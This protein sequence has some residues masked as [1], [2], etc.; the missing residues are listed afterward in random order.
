[1]TPESFNPF[2]PPLHRE[3]VGR[4]DELY[5][6]RRSKFARIGWP[7]VFAL[8]LVVPVMLVV[9]NQ[10][11]SGQLGAIAAFIMLLMMGWRLCCQYPDFGRKLVIGSIFVAL[12]QVF[13]I[14]HF[15]A[16]IVAS[17]VLSLFSHRA[18]LNKAGRTLATRS[19]GYRRQRLATACR[20][21][22]VA[23]V[24]DETKFAVR[25]GS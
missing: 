10:P 9:V 7:V 17:I 5:A 19:D 11:W 25:S 6:Q 18:D 15:W 8:N 16:G 3:R 21:S 4:F 14:I 2:D 13:P 1:M 24:R 23:R 20:D 22:G 12:S